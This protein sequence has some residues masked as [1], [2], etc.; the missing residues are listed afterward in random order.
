MNTD[1]I[2]QQQLKS[3]LGT[4]SEDELQVVFNLFIKLSKFEVDKNIK[5]I[6]YKWFI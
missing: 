4:L 1:K 3:V 2:Q 6:S 5:M